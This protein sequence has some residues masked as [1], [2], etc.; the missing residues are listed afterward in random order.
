MPAY[1]PHCTRPALTIASLFAAVF[2]LGITMSPQATAQVSG[3]PTP[4]GGSVPKGSGT[5]AMPDSIVTTRL[6]GTDTATAVLAGGCFWCMESDFEKCPGVLDIISGYTGGRSKNPTYKTY[7]TGGHRE[8]V[9][10]AYD[11]TKI[12]FKGISEWLVKHIDPTDSQGQF[13]DRGKHYS[14]AIY[15]TTDEEKLAAQEVIKALDGAKLFGKKKVNVDVRRRTEFFP[16]E[17]YHQNYHNTN[18]QEYMQYRAGTGRDAFITKVWG[19]NANKL[20]L[21]GSV[22]EQ[23]SS[24]GSPPA[25]DAAKRPW[26]T[27]KKPSAEDLREKLTRMQYIVTQS[28]GT[29]PAFQNEYWDNKKA[30]I[31]VDV[32]SGAPLFS[33]TD[34]YKSGTG[35]PSFVQPIEPDAVTYKVDYKMVVPRTEVRSR[36]GNSHLGHVFSDGPASRGGKRYCMNSASMRFIPVDRLEEEG[37]GQYLKLFK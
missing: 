13:V 26:V 34:K 3:S 9:L 31:Y 5:A 2:L 21:P 1:P 10:I 11:P 24:E 28:D 12:T 17:D 15:F 7:S 20:Q 18:P 19:L 22:P 6:P 25:S 30:G 29:E 36:Y 27:F 16:A 23:A 4:Q 14:P 33:S 32:V 37:Y 8:A 35:W